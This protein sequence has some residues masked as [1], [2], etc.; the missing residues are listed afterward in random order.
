MV[1]FE[2]KN[3]MN[4]II[5]SSV[6]MLL[7]SGVLSCH[8][9]LVG[10]GLITWSS[11]V[12]A[13]PELYCVSYY[14]VICCSLS[15]SAISWESPFWQR[16]CW[17]KTT[18]DQSVVQTPGQVSSGIAKNFLLHIYCNVTSRQHILAWIDLVACLPESRAMEGGGLG[19]VMAWDYNTSILPLYVSG[20][21]NKHDQQN[22][23]A[24]SEVIL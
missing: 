6:F 21:G 24:V 18:G 4:W 14:F 17:A 15:F 2:T 13:S 10:I 16:K 22:T 19:L 20:W 9:P 7:Y 23:S 12:Q 3:K 1:K 11:W 8:G 5:M